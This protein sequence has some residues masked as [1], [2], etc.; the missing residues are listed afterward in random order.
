MGSIRG[1][2][3]R[4]KKYEHPRDGKLARFGITNDQYQQ[5]LAQQG[6]LCAICHRVPGTRR[7]SVDHCHSTLRVRGLL[8]YMCNRFRVGQARDHEVELY[9]RITGYLQSDFDGRAL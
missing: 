1:H 5:M 7:L 4:P 2:S 3:N 9:A 6:G 8:C